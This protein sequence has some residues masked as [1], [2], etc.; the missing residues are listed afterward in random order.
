MT[1]LRGTSM[2]EN[3][4]LL[5]IP[6][7]DPF[8]PENLRLD[9][10]FTEATGVKKL[11]TTVPVRKPKPQDFIRVHSDEAYR[12]DVAIIELEE[13]RENYLVTPN[14]A[15]DLQN[16]LRVKTLF[17]AINRQGMVFL[18]PVP[19][20]AAD[21]RILEWH[22]SLREGAEMAMRRWVRVQANRNMGAYEI[23]EA[24]GAIPEPTWPDVPFRELLRIAFRDR[25]ID[26]LD[27]PVV[28]QL[29]GG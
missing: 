8:D 15:A 16:E 14:T 7:A 18:L 6:S 12:A 19:V 1:R 13:E 22:R 11:L 26:R 10:S 20:T 5:N 28:R 17:T 3:A 4:K 21:M 25:F 24:T 27:H 2:S 23:S 29:R 9:Q